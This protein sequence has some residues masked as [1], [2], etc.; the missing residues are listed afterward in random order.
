MA[1]PSNREPPLTGAAVEIDAGDTST[2]TENLR[3]GADLLMAIGD[4]G[5]P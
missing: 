1:F 3:A 2:L 4:A 5:R